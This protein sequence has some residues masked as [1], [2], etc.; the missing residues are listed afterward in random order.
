MEF[1]QDDFFYYLKI[2]QNIAAGHGST[3]NGLVRTNGYHP[4]YEVLLVLLSKVS[5]NPK[6]IL[7]FQ[8]VMTFL[9]AAVTFA[10]SIHLISRSGLRLL[11]ALALSTWFTLYALR[12]F[13]YGMEVTLTIPLALATIALTLKFSFWQRG[14]WQA[15]IFGLLISA[16]VLSR[17]DAI[18]LV[19]LLAVAIACSP[20]TLQNMRAPVMLGILFGL[21]PLAGYF[22]FNHHAFGT[23]LP[24]S[25]MAKQLKVGISPSAKVWND[26]YWFLPSFFLVMLPIPVAIIS[27]LFLY[28]KTSRLNFG[29]YMATLWFPWVYYFVVS[30]RSDWPIW[31]WYMYALRPAV[32]ISFVVLCMCHP[33]KRLL[34]SKYVVSAMLLVFFAYLFSSS[35][36]VQQADLY[37]TSLELQ[38]FEKTHPGIYAMGD[39]SGSVG[40]LMKSPMVQTEGL[41][42]DKAFL[43][44]IREQRPL[45]DV[46]KEYGVRYYVGT[47]SA[48][49]QMPGDGC[50][51]AEEPFLAGPASPKMRAV[52]C[53]SPVFKVAVPHGRETFVYDLQ[54]P[55]AS[56]PASH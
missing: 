34:E 48:S 2:A 23:W 18:F 10:L 53:Q 38:K 9:A 51:H 8:A 3:F 24:I 40:Y 35:W 28:K 50:F 27:L 42:M 19:A 41:V 7:L 52:F 43:N 56:G 31:G 25:G 29:V 49:R 20:E 46:L 33:I 32:C 16:T 37:A 39:R 30:C 47:F 1:T 15:F 45:L 26:L 4:L 13:Y 54:Q 11:S 14:F 12:M 36:T 5:R 6:V 44:K 17:L 55:N 21:V 22:V